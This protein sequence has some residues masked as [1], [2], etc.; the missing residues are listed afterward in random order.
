MTDPTG[1]M[2]EDQV[3]QLDPQQNNSSGGAGIALADDSVMEEVTATGTRDNGGA[4]NGNTSNYVGGLGSAG[5]SLMA[6]E[7]VVTGGHVRSHNGN[8]TPLAIGTLHLVGPLN[9]GTP[10]TPPPPPKIGSP[11]GGCMARCMIGVKV[12][13]STAGGAVSGAV[14]GLAGGPA[15]IA[16]GATAGAIAGAIAGSLEIAFDVESPSP[17]AAVIGAAAGGIAAANNGGNALAGAMAS[18]ATGGLGPVAGTGV[19]AVAAITSGGTVTSNV[20]TG[21]TPGAGRALML[22]TRGILTGFGGIA[23]FIIQQGVQSAG[24]AACTKL[25][26]N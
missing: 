24:E 12:A 25:C 21:V 7:V 20:F 1:F 19:D 18:A 6:P 13:A 17:G 26:A 2:V 3:P 8:S 10:G 16:T 15:G 9:I 14:N 22:G 11:K 5:N 23:G 4:A